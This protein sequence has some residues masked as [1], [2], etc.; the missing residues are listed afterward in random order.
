MGLPGI[1]VNGDGAGNFLLGTRRDDILAGAGGNDSLAAGMGDDTLYGGTGDDS[2]FV[3]LGNDFHFGGEGVDTLFFTFLDYSSDGA[4]DINTFGVTFD[5]AIVGLQDLGYLGRDYFYGFENVFG[6][7]GNDRLFGDA[8]GNTLD[9]YF[10][11]DFVN[12]RGGND[13][14]IGSAGAD[15]LI[16]GAGAD[17][18]DCFFLA[19]GNDGA[20]DTVRYSAVSESGTGGATRDTILSFTRG[21]AATADRIDLSAIDA[22]PFLA[23]NQKFIFIGAAA[24]R[25]NRVGEVRII[26]LGADVL[27]SIDADSDN[28]PEMTIMVDNVGT[29]TAGDFIL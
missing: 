8:G 20:R 23:G 9:G 26:D 1:Q 2:V 28:N 3:D 25:A 7:Y 12:G 17:S 13:I 29:L 10:G 4:G 21:A 24:F 27:V 11:N 14:L 6:S 15:V 19:F 5:L 18:I 22:N 16:G